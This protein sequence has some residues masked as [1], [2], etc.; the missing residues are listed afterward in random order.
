MIL[1]QKP[2]RARRPPPPFH[3]RRRRLGLRPSERGIGNAT[4]PR[5]APPPS[6]AGSA[7]CARFRS[8]RRLGIAPSC[9][10]LTAILAQGRVVGLGGC[11]VVFFPLLAAAAGDSRGRQNAGVLHRP[12]GGHPRGL[13]PHDDDMIKIARVAG[14][15]TGRAVG[16]L[17]LFRRQMDEILEQT[18]AKQVNKE[19]KDAM[20]QLDSIRYEV[21]NLSRFTPGQFMRQHNPVGVDHEAEK[22]DAVDGSALN[23]EELRHQI[24]SMVHDEI[25]SFYKTNPDKFSGRLDNADTVNR[26]GPVEGKEAD[27]AVIPTMLASKDM[28]LANTGST[29]LHSKATMYSRLTESPEMSG[30]S[31]HQFKESDGLLNILPISAESAG[32]LPSRSDKP[33]GSDL[34]LEATLEAE[35]AEHAKSFAQ[36]HH[37]ELHKE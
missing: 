25:E 8:T 5:A 21:Q 20:T 29:D 15:M 32:L 34:L 13:L 23:L 12:V 37:D 31:G 27:V 22:N 30:S 19:L 16:R 14:R 4:P 9:S 24:R 35:V 26:S 10:S 28:K 3:A 7:G 17:M 33:Q 11:K 18:A 2:A 6:P 1:Q 36:Q